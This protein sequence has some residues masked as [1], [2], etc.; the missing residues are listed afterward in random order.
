MPIK[1]G[2]TTLIISSVFIALLIAAIGIMELFMMD[3]LY[4]GPELRLRFYP[5]TI[6]NLALALPVLLLSLILVGIKKPIGLIIWS[7]SLFF[8][9]YQYLTLLLSMPFGIS[10]PLYLMVFCL[11]LYSLIGL[12]SAI[13][14]EQLSSALSGIIP[15]RTFGSILFGLGSIVL[16]RQAGLFI[17]HLKAS[18]AATQSDIALWISDCMISPALIIL[19]VMLWQKKAFAYV[20]AGSVFFGFGLL[21]LGVI[22]VFM[23]QEKMKG[24]SAGPVDISVLAVFALLCLVPFMYFVKGTK[25]ID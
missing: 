1:R 21:S 8:I 6:I 18:T 14:S 7:G 9:L 3:T 16:A 23:M 20:G 12:M 25:Q 13:Q 22:P 11:S 10:F 24:A 2:I 5:N 15:A 17:S 4:P 19:G